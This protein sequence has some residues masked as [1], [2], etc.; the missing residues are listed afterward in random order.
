[1]LENYIRA[2]VILVGMNIGLCSPAYA[3]QWEIHSYEFRRV[4]TPE[5]GD[6]SS[7]RITSSALLTNLDTG[8]VML[9]NAYFGIRGINVPFPGNSG[10]SAGCGRIAFSGSP[11][12]RGTGRYAFSVSMPF[13][14][15]RLANETVHNMIAHWRY[16]KTTQI[17][18]FC[19]F[20]MFAGETGGSKWHCNEAVIHNDENICQ[21]LQQC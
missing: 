17:T 5:T 18:S 3:D 20:T 12:E 21:V 19:L 8:E 6:P 13:F 14:G 7:W 11:P 10:R 9:C 1:M 15:A 2:I 4:L 16:D